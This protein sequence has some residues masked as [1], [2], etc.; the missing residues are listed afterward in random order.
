MNIMRIIHIGY[1]DSE[2]SHLIIPYEH[3]HGF[4][5]LISLFIYFLT[6]IQIGPSSFYSQYIFF[7]L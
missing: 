6:V 2:G 7:V 1:I 3:V 4:E 5:L